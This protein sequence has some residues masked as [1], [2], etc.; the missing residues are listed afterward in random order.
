MFPLQLDDSKK[1]T[2]R[3]QG[4]NREYP[5]NLLRTIKRPSATQQTAKQMP[6]K[7]GAGSQIG[8]NDQ[9][10]RTST[11]NASKSQKLDAKSSEKENRSSPPA[12]V[13]VIVKPVA[14]AAEGDVFRMPDSDSDPDEDK[15]PRPSFSSDDES[16]SR[17]SADMTKTLGVSKG[18]KTNTGTSQSPPNSKAGKSPRTQLNESRKRKNLEPSSKHDPKLGMFGEITTRKKSRVSYTKTYKEPK[19]PRGRVI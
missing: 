6:I 14:D 1:F 4:L 13:A 7:I 5:V 8:E 19:F 15:P 11:S 12:S 2:K 17:I 10:L 16:P 3:R 9:A 18:I